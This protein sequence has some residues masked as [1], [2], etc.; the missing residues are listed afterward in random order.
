ML[1]AP[2]SVSRVPLVTYRG[3][4]SRRRAW[5]ISRLPRFFENGVGIPISRAAHPASFHHIRSAAIRSDRI[6]LRTSADAARD[7]GSSKALIQSSLISP[8]L[9][10]MRM[11]PR[12]ARYPPR[13]TDQ[14]HHSTPT[15]R[16]STVF[17]HHDKRGAAL[18]QHAQCRAH[19]TRLRDGAC[20]AAKCA[21]IHQHRAPTARILL[22]SYS[23]TA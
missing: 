15:R 20:L 22:R 21:S 11:A 16:S 2:L 14:Y 9:S 18:H 8:A 10:S 6:E 12:R 13:T 19:G 3:A 23:R 17:T 5:C 1:R 7:H 4:A